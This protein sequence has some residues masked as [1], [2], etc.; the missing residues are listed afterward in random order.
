M[1]VFNLLFC[2]FYKGENR[3]TEKLNNFSRSHSWKVEVRPQPRSYA[4]LLG[5]LPSEFSFLH[6]DTIAPDFAVYIR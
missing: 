5:R 3:S 6:L 1:T 2:P 4:H